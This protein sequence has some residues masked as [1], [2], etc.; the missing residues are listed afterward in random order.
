MPRDRDAAKCL[1]I[2]LTDMLNFSGVNK[3]RKLSFS[4]FDNRSLV[5]VYFWS[6]FSA[7][8]HSV[9]H[10][11]IAVLFLNLLAKVLYPHHIYAGYS[12]SVR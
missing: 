8:L 2:I 10:E 1:F 9:G 3:I 12:L 7:D 4:R 6:V 11:C 5:K